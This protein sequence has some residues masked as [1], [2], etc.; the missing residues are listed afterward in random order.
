M[1]LWI[2]VQQVCRDDAK[3]TRMTSSDDEDALKELFPTTSLPHEEH[4]TYV[5]RN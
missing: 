1:E 3:T 5:A 2:L 4:G